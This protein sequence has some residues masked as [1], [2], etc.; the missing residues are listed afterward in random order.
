MVDLAS[1]IART[2]IGNTAVNLLIRWMPPVSAR[3]CVSR[4]GPRRRFDPSHPRLYGQAEQPGSGYGV[5]RDRAVDCAR[6]LRR[7][8]SE[9]DGHDRRNGRNAVIA[10]VCR[11]NSDLSIWNADFKL[12]Q[13]RSMLQTW[14]R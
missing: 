14:A 7:F 11:I 8:W 13:C 2:R 3:H 6:A 9:M 10:I 5:S 1:Q 12:R 4:S